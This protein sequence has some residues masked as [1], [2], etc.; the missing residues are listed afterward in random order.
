MPPCKNNPKKHY[1]GDEPS[2]KGLGFCASAEEVGTTMEGRDGKLYIVARRQKSKYWRLVAS[3]KKH[4]EFAK[5]TRRLTPTQ[6]ATLKF[7]C[8]PTFAKE[9]RAAGFDIVV[10]YLPINKGVWFIDWLWE[11]VCEK[12]GDK[13]MESMIIVP[14]KIDDYGDLCIFDGGMY[15][16]HGLH[17]KAQRETVYQIF[18]KHFTVEW[19][20]SER[21]AIFVKL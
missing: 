9:L 3:E 18:S 12:Y 20:K 2:P 6:L 8:G 5:I 14:L 1:V 17:F 7:L 21:K 16:Q 13:A 10:E 15:L 4:F 11:D 19:N